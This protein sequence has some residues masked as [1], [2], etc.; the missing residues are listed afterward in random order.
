VNKRQLAD[1]E[2]AKESYI[3]VLQSLDEMFQAEDLTVLE[4][5]ARFKREEFSE[6][7]DKFKA[8]ANK[9]LEILRQTADEEQEKYNNLSENL[10]NTSR[11]EGISNNAGYLGDAAD[12]L[13]ILLEKLVSD[14]SDFKSDI[15]TLDVFLNDALGVVNELYDIADVLEEIE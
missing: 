5:A 9:F 4:K 2:K 14:M 6:I 13:E 7:Y 1:L 15:I 12:N 3:D 11:A 8:Q 10:K